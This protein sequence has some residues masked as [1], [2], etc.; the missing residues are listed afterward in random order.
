MG[1]VMSRFNIVSFIAAAGIVLAVGCITATPQ[2]EA[3][4]AQETVVIEEAALPEEPQP[5]RG[6]LVTKALAVAYP[7]RIEKA[8]FRDDDWALLMDGVWY[9]YAGG[10]FLPEEMLEKADEYSGSFY[11]YNYQRELP[12]WREPSPEQAAR[13]SGNDSN[14]RNNTRNTDGENDRP[15]IQRQRSHFFSEGLW[16]AGSRDESSRQVKSVNFLGNAV[17]VHSD[18]VE[19]LSL[20]EERIMAAATADPQLQSWI[21]GIG[22]IHGW[23]WRNVAGSQS[24]SYHSYGIAID[25]LPKSLGGKETYWQWAAQRGREWWNIPYADRYHPPNAVIKAF[26]AYGFI[27]GGKWVAFDTMH[28]EYRPEVLFLNGLELITLQ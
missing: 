8:E 18:I 28:F 7:R 27:W 17:T 16:R 21:T 4:L 11:L 15:R 2:A 22:E 12:P 23:N 26:E 9:Y 1:I 24:R 13:F 5:A 20:I 6:E 14:N 3:Q 10:R 19:V 25:I